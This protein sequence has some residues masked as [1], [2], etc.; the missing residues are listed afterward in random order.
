VA[1][2]TLAAGDA[3]TDVSGI[4]LLPLAYLLLEV[5]RVG[6]DITL[7]RRMA[8]SLGDTGWLCAHIH[9]N[10]SLLLVAQV[11]ASYAFHFGDVGRVDGKG[12]VSSAVQNES[13]CYVTGCFFLQ[14]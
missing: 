10:E 2:D 6:H 7:N 13:R 12:T 1:K 9:A 4:N 14:V 5:S 8:E 3:L 11:F